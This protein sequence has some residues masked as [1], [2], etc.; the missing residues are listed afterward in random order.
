M[1]VAIGSANQNENYEMSF[2]QYDVKITLA[3]DVGR[4]SLMM[5]VLPHD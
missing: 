3:S 4:Q 1:I 2:A 5:P